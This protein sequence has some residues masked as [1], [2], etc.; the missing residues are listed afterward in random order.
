MIKGAAGHTEAARR[1]PARAVI[2]AQQK[3]KSQRHR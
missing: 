3:T 2:A 1:E